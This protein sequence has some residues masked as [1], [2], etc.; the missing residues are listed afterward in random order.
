MFSGPF[1]LGQSAFLRHFFIMDPMNK[2]QELGFLPL[3]RLTLEIQAC[4]VEIGWSFVQ[5]PL[6][7]QGTCSN[8]Y[9]S[10]TLTGSSAAICNSSDYVYMLTY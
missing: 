5:A 3:L 9:L 6:W 8:V 7:T 10:T 4:R 2:S 1:E